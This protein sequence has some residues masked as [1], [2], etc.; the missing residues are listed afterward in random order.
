MRTRILLLISLLLVS[1]AAPAQERQLVRSAVKAAENGLARKTVVPAAAKRLAETEKAAL[2]S[3]SAPLPPAYQRVTEEQ[4]SH[5]H[6]SLGAIIRTRQTQQEIQDELFSR[7]KKHFYKENMVPERLEKS[8][9]SHISFVQRNYSQIER[10]MSQSLESRANLNYRVQ[11]EG[12]Q[13]AV[14]GMT[15]SPHAWEQ[16]G[17]I[18]EQLRQ[19]Q[20]GKTVLVA[21]Q[22]PFP[23]EVTTDASRAGTVVFFRLYRQKNLP[24]HAQAREWGRQI[25][26]AKMQLA[27]GRAA[28]PGREPI[29]LVLAAHA[30]ADGEIGQLLDKETA[31]S[32][33]NNAVHISLRTRNLPD[34]TGFKSALLTGP[35]K[36]FPKPFA[37]NNIYGALVTS[38]G[39]YGR[40]IGTD[41]LVEF[42]PDKTLRNLR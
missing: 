9:R 6:Q 35:L 14:V 13:T 25:V 16:A 21:S 29:T 15:P 8:I 37:N 30:Y 32:F 39:P 4:I 31:V 27:G 5:A 2:G 36:Q 12:K 1:V 7:W 24:P 3:V 41:L 18:L 26:A 20:P 38:F 28:F 19:T 23:G 10:T 17:R 33:F 34:I 22:F 42:T 11:L 40:Q